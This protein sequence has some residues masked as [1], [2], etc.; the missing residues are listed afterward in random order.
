[1]IERLEVAFDR[2]RQFTADAS[3][4]LRT[5][6]AVIQAETSLT[7]GRE[8]TKED[9]QES[10][11]MVSQ[12][13]SY[14]SAIIEKLLFLARSDSGKEPVTFRDINL[15]DLLGEVYADAAALAREKNIELKME[16][17]EDITIKG[18]AVKLRQLFLNILENAVRYTPE[19]GR[20]SSSLVRRDGRAVVTISDTG[21]GIP[22]EHLPY[23]FDR[24]Y[25]VDKARSRA[26]GGTG[27]G[28]AIA[29]QIA[30]SHGG[31]IEV[32]SE[33]GK[34]STFRVLL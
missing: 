17:V 10:L 1:M 34:G 29:R 24:F 32:E 19:G 23:I 20:I 27:L 5:P 4:E 16:P 28:L 9:L 2:Q 13:V 26:E 18:D 14:M 22:A 7:L 3:H 25:R 21:I 30:E 8:R 12:E 33:A 31:S 15:R 11:E 6:L